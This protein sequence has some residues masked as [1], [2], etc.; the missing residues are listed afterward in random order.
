MQIKK[1][2]TLVTTDKIQDAKQ[3]YTEHLG[4]RVTFEDP[5]QHLC[6]RSTGDD[7]VEVSFMAP[8]EESPAFAG[9]GLILSLEV[10][11]PDSEHARLADRGLPIV[12]PL[13]DNPW[14]DRS[15]IVVDP[16]GVALYLYKEIPP[17]EKYAACYVE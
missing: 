14:G 10:G 8:C 15:F 11:D 4:F 16:A 9:Q 1:S 12:R 2:T 5:G 6:L 3:F 17:N 13:Q 7:G